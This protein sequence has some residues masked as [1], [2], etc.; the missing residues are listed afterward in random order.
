MK[1]ILVL[2]FV[3]FLSSCGNKSNPEDFKYELIDNTYTI[4]SYKGDS[5]N[6]VIPN[7]YNDIAVTKIKEEAFIDAKITSIT[8]GDNITHIYKNAFSNSTIKKITFNDKISYIGDY[9]FYGCQSLS[10][11][12]FPSSLTYLGTNSLYL[13]SMYNQAKDNEFLYLGDILYGYKGFITSKIEL[14]VKE[15]TRLIAASSF[16]R[17]AT[18]TS[19]GITKLTIPNSIKYINDRAFFKCGEITSLEINDCI[20]IGTYAFTYAIKY[21]TLLVNSQTIKEYAFSDC[22]ITNIELGDNVQLIEAYAFKTSSK[23]SM[24]STITIPTNVNFIGA[25]AFGGNSDLVITNNSFKPFDSKWNYYDDST[26]Y[27][28]KNALD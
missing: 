2:F 6:V 25:L 22:L 21:G 1:K 7:E 18:E 16:E 5:K 23:G 8:L 4:T 20:E 27:E 28:T 3:L 9:C 24:Y 17:P 13:T 26:Q 10:I 15:G 19:Y 12:S 14:N 11:S